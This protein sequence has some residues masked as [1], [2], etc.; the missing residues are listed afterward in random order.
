VVDVYVGDH[1]V[2][3][4]RVSDADFF[5]ACE[6]VRDGACW[7]CFDD[8][9]GF[10]SFEHVGGDEVLYACGFQVYDVQVAAEL[11]CV[12]DGSRWSMQ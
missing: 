2:V 10:G 9:G 6:Q 1:D 11:F 12:H 8:C 3:D 7:A 4:F 5:Q